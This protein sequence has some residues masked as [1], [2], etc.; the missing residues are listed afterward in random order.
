MMTEIN[1]RVSNEKSKMF[2]EMESCR[3]EV[4]NRLHEL[5]AEAGPNYATLVES[6]RYS[7]LAGGKRVRA[8]LCIK[9]CQ[10]AGGRAEDAISAACAIEMLHTYTLIHDD[11]PSMDGDDLRRGKPSNHVEY[12]E[13]T[14]T[15]AGDALQA[16]AFETLANSAL[17]PESVVEMVKILA[18]AAG[19][20]GIC[21][22]QYLDLSGEGWHLTIDELL[23]LYSMKTA[24]LISAAARLGVIAG[25]GTQQQVD[26]AHSYAQAIGLAF[27]VR[28][29]VLDCIATTEE[30][31][32]PM[33]SDI[34]SEKSTFVSLLGVETCEKMINRETGNA[35]ASIS[36]K[37]EN[38]EFLTWLAQ[39]LAQRRS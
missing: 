35:I 7:L 4:D 24:A 18:H 14:A 30:L 29:D 13:F 11:L 12:G 38:T 27:Q 26:A 9:F 33:G 10:A 21:A 6:M 1:D 19:P 37:F 8:I 39:I 34:E 20:H 28:D 2:Q 22:G 31:G 17:P 25:N 36:G 16:A 23:E 15:L 32:K 5:L 3:D